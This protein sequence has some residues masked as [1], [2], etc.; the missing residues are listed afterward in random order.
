[1]GDVEDP[2]L[3]EVEKC[4]GSET[5]PP[6][7]EEGSPCR[8]R[9]NWSVGILFG[10]IWIMYVVWI[11]TST[12]DAVIFLVRAPIPPAPPSLRPFHA[13]AEPPRLPRCPRAVLLRGGGHHRCVLG[14]E[15]K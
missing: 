1:M 4:C 5:C 8:R 12:V 15:A 13:E 6:G 9:W 14:E 2:E 10:P 7:Y 11:I 3:F